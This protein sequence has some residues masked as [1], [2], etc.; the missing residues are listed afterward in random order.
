MDESGEQPKFIIQPIIEQRPFE[1]PAVGSF[2]SYWC[3]A[4]DS[5]EPHVITRQLWQKKAEKTILEKKPDGTH[6]LYIP[7][8]LQLWE[9]IGVMEAVDHD[10]FADNPNKRDEAKNK[11]LSLGRLFQNSGIY[12]AKRLDAIH[13]G[14][15]MARGLAEEFYDY[16]KALITGQKPAQIASAENIAGLDLSPAETEKVDR[17]LAGENL[18]LARQKKAQK[19]SLTE[20][21]VR[22]ETLGQFFR[23]TQKAYDLSMKANLSRSPK[24]EYPWLNNAPIHYAFLEKIK[25]SLKQNI[26]LP[27]K[28]LAFSIFRRGMELL[29]KNMPFDKLPPDIKNLYLHWQNGEKTLHEALDIDGLKMMLEKARRTGNLQNIANTERAIADIIQ[30]AV[31]HYSYKTSANNPSEMIASQQ[32]NCLGASML[33]GTLMAEIGL[34]YL[35]GHVPKHS[36]LFLITND[37]HVEWRDMLDSNFNE[38]LFD[39][40]I[41]GEN[42]HGSPLT[43]RDIVD[44]SKNPS[45][46]GLLFHIADRKY[47]EK[48]PGLKKGQ[49]QFI[50]LFAPE[51]GQFIQL[52]NN[53]GS[54]LLDLKLFP[55]AEF[56]FRQAISLDPQYAYPYNG[57]GIA[58]YGQGDIVSAMELYRQA[59]AMDPDS[60][61]AY[62][63]LGDALNHIGHYMDALI[64]F[65]QTINLDPQYAFAYNGLGD[66]LHKLDRD[67]E[68]IQAYQAFIGL[69]DKEKDV[70]WIKR[71]EKIIATLQ[72]KSEKSTI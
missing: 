63:N 71:A 65:R 64:S 39:E 53:T 4:N 26:E 69:A 59:I 34:N 42:I 48:I 46:R 37:G 24:P 41:Q 12:I 25:K 70:Y 27:Q 62:C 57:L 3:G 50:A 20:E 61:T 6:V 5:I 60:S 68:T 40:K 21:K 45:P 30:S 29:W 11:I 1:N 22:R 9:M 49:R 51:Q 8:D 16:G 13:D 19:Y 67:K 36:V 15:S 14:K 31:S 17:F 44:F 72:N 52:L 2:F 38:D 10:T 47:R 35:V 7:A 33:G 18:Y 55:E 43:V 28:E 54:T 23:T 58:L 66:A 32:L 56:C